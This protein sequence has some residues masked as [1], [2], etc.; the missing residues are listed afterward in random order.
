MAFAFEFPRF[1]PRAGT[2]PRP[3]CRWR[4]RAINRSHR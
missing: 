4:E 3:S 2:A 1:N